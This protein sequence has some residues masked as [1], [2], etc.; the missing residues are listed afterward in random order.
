[1]NTENQ[2]LQ[3]DRMETEK[4]QEHQQK[5][6][7]SSAER[8]IGMEF[9]PVLDREDILREQRAAVT[10]EEMRRSM[11]DDI[12]PVV[13]SVLELTHLMMSGHSQRLRAAPGYQGGLFYGGRPFC[14][15]SGYRDGTRPREMDDKGNHMKLKDPLTYGVLSLPVTAGYLCELHGKGLFNL[16]TPLVQYLPELQQKLDETITARSIL[17]FTRVIDDRQVL[18]DAGVK[19]MRPH[20]SWNICAATQEYVYEPLNRFFAAGSS[21]PLTGQQQRENFI[22][23]LR[24]S[25]HVKV[26]SQLPRG[27]LGWHFRS[28]SHF[29]VAL[30]IAAVER[31]LKEV[32]FEAS[33]RKT[34]FEPAQSHGAGYG[35][36]KLWR[37]PNELFYQPSGLSLQ[38][39][40]FFHPLKVGSVENSAPPLL[41]ASINLHAP[42][43]DYGKLLLLSLDAI[44]HAR[45]ALGDAG[46]EANNPHYDFGVEWL[47]ND[48]CLQL[49]Q[50]VL[51]IDYLPSA[52]SFRY[53]CNHDLGC[54][55]VSNCGT[56][57]A[58]MLA[59]TLSRMIQH[60]FLKHVIEKGVDAMR[61]P[62]L[63]NPN[64]ESS[65]T[66]RKF[67][68]VVKQQ[69][70]TSYFKK[71]EAHKRF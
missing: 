21:T 39:Q 46:I 51:G 58:R 14:F 61:G 19:W 69:E 44:R 3:K 34:V 24:T 2:E 20:F 26:V 57:N 52:S 23:Y 8:R 36:P 48:R 42:V 63:D 13:R 7:Q 30:L 22:Q 60:L 38:H 37:D 15:A 47:N 32:S 54:F 10:P 31:Q 17:A 49:T 18:R 41:N 16:H 25:P 64:E 40:G 27:K 71:H 53:S 28:V 1:M 12:P 66:E 70:Y 67:R 50:R 65:A 62:D 35:P 45:T 6:A 11:Q 29:S 4:P 56:R 5:T 9:P 43:E 68:K 33:I 55:G 59:N